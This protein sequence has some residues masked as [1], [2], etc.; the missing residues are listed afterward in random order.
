M[1]Y[2]FHSFEFLPYGASMKIE[3]TSSNKEVANI[4][5]NGNTYSTTYGSLGKGKSFFIESKTQPISMTYTCTSTNGLLQSISTNLQYTVDETYDYDGVTYIKKFTINNENWF[6]EPY[7]IEEVAVTKSGKQYVGTIS[8][9]NRN[10]I[11]EDCM[12]VNKEQYLP[13]TV[14][15]SKIYINVDD[16]NSTTVNVRFAKTKPF[17][18]LCCNKVKIEASFVEIDR[19]NNFDYIDTDVTYIYPAY[20]NKCKA[21]FLRRPIISWSLPEKNQYFYGQTDS[22]QGPNYYG[23]FGFYNNS[24][25]T[26]GWTIHA[27]TKNISSTIPAINTLNNPYYFIGYTANF[28]ELDTYA[29]TSKRYIS[30]NLTIYT[31]DGFINSINGKK[32]FDCNYYTGAPTFYSLSIWNGN[33]FYKLSDEDD[34]YISPSDGFIY[35]TDW[36]I[37]YVCSC[38]GECDPDC[39]CDGECECDGECSNDG[40]GSDT[41]IY[42]HNEYNGGSTGGVAN[43]QS[44]GTWYDNGN[45]IFIPAGQYKVV[46]WAIDGGPVINLDSSLTGYAISRYY[47]IL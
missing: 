17:V 25:S 8:T 13:F 22:N 46:A 19:P 39:G 5:R 28:G 42:S 41:Y 35:N 44:D 11:I 26:L 4:I 29:L 27:G 9:I 33:Q 14:S 1:I 6:N 3:C 36:N 40:G 20:K 45:V 7:L 16:Y 2:K 47:D 34:Y 21:T 31:E 43:K 38:D 10:K 18:R 32:Y 37:E 23:V 12:D 24:T 30:G 15:S